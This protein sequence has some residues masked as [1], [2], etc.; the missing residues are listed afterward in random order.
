MP[1][2]AEFEILTDRSQYDWVWDSVNSGYEVT[3][4][5]NGNKIF[6]PGNG[7]TF[8]QNTIMNS[9]VMASYW[10]SSLDTSDQRRA[11][12]MTCYDPSSMPSSQQLSTANRYQGMFVRPV[13]SIE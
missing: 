8:V 6:L 5:A 3:C 9:G 7:G 1:T 2:K 10:S 11:Y 4:K 13:A 12:Y